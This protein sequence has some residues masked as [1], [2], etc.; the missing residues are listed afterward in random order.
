MFGIAF[1]WS[2]SGLVNRYLDEVWREDVLV[3]TVRPLDQVA[4]TSNMVICT[5]HDPVTKS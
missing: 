3:R 1:C 4:Q 2:I 5:G